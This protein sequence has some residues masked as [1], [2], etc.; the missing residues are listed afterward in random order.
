MSR[1]F[2]G[3]TVYNAESDTHFPHLTVKQTLEFAAAL[4]M[5]RN[6][7]IGNSR[8]D[9]IQQMTAVAMAVCGL[10]HVHDVK[11]GSDYVR[12]VSGGER[13]VIDGHPGTLLPK[14]TLT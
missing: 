7:I 9:H 11:V 4:R 12:G 6:R 13:K 1:N 10:T 14:S 5:P 2:K 3:E 8:E